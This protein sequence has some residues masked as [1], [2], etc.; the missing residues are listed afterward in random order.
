MGAPYPITILHGSQGSGKSTLTNALKKLID[1][2]KAPLIRIGDE[3]NFAIMANNTH[4]MAIDNLSSLSAEQSDLLCTAS[5]GG[6]FRTRALH[7]ND[8]EAIFEYRR[9]IV[10]NGIDSIATRGDLLDRAIL[11]PVGRPEKRLAERD[12]WTQFESA[13]PQMFGA[14]CDALAIGLQNLPNVS[15]PDDTRMV[16]FAEFG[17]ALE[18][19]LG[20]QDGDF[21]RFYLNTKQDA[22]ETA[23][24][25]SP[26]AQA[27]FTLMENYPDGFGGTATQLLERLEQPSGGF[28]KEQ[29]DQFK[30]DRLWPKDTTR[31]S[32]LLGRLEPD[33]RACGIEYTTSR[34]SGGNRVRFLS[35]K[36]VN[37]ASLASLN[38]QSPHSESVLDRDATKKPSVPLASQTPSSVPPPELRDA[39]KDRDANENLASRLEPA[40]SEDSDARDARDAKN[41]YV[42]G[43]KVEQLQ[44]K[45]GDRVVFI[46]SNHAYLDNG[47]VLEVKE[48]QGT[49]AICDHSRGIIINIRI[50]IA[51]LRPCDRLPRI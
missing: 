48:V 42:R 41:P 37:V 8:D 12:L 28:A 32:K 5:T 13:R 19:A 26:V 14:I 29:I 33:L 44:L 25:S 35:L 10:M 36:K 7:T 11:I 9:P 20:L 22:H 43:E 38:P 18:P 4:L 39:T 50:P 2:S 1:P 49:I 21:M 47:D 15:I 3:R 45:P 34:Q 16:D 46:G 24:E 30:R 31:L 17:T 6:G 27:I 23:I 40:H 51:D